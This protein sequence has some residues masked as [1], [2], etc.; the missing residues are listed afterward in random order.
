MTP[1]KKKSQ[2]DISVNSTVNGIFVF[3]TVYDHWLD[4]TVNT[5]KPVL[6]VNFSITGMCILF[7]FYL[8]FFINKLP[9]YADALIIIKIKKSD[10]K[11]F[12]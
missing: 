8:I 2:T 1:N 9:K 3:Y 10:Q 11:C 12:Y 7:N 6:R 4:P 5:T